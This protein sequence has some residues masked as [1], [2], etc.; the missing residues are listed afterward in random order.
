[1]G[2]HTTVSIENKIERRQTRGKL[3]LAVWTEA[4]SGESLESSLTLGIAN[5]F[6]CFIQRTFYQSAEIEYRFI[7]SKIKCCSLWLWKLLLL[8][9][10]INNFQKVKKTDKLIHILRVH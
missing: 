5:I 2:E 1:M 4:G 7:V 9:T 10:S 8:S 6:T 3:T